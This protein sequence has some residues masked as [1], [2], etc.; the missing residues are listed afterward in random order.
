MFKILSG[1][2]EK[3]AI[4]T[5]DKIIE[6]KGWNATTTLLNNAES[7]R[8]LSESEIKEI[9]YNADYSK[10]TKELEKALT[11]TK[12]VCFEYKF[13]NGKSFKAIADLSVY[14]KI[15]KSGEKTI[16]EN[17][18]SKT[19][20]NYGCL[21][22]IIIA[23]SFFVLI[24][25]SGDSDKPL[26]SFQSYGI[27]AN[28]EANIR[29]ALNQIGIDS[30]KNIKQADTNEYELF[31]DKDNNSVWVTLRDDKVKTI[32]TTKEILAIN[33]QIT[34]VPNKTIYNNG[35]VI[36][37]IQDYILTKDEF[38]EYQVMA[39]NAVLQ[40]LKSP[41]TAE[42]PTSKDW[43]I[44][45][46]NGVVTARSFVDSQNGFGAM[47]RMQFEIKFSKNNKV[48]SFKHS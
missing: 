1:D 13:K 34:T 43:D 35:K 41:K 44:S 5:N 25:S 38:Y 23:F 22:V 20:F 45:K 32:E 19:S 21:A 24:A 3:T 14:H 36:G 10:Y 33:Q 28:Q 47:I 40:T 42:F 16:D 17:K 9:I 46:E 29:T 30:V 26:S 6:T 15:Q 12:I 39:E 8:V 31:F 27:S 37:K 18:I 2:F 48:I 7:T 11:G 4:Y